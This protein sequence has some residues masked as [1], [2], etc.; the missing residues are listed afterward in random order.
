VA[1]VLAPVN[2]TQNPTIPGLTA[3]AV[4][5]LKPLLENQLRGDKTALAVSQKMID[6]FRDWIDAAD[7]YRHEQ[8]DQDIAQPPTTVAATW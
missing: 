4:E 8:G 2:S 7:N 3:K 5:R 6:S 1:A